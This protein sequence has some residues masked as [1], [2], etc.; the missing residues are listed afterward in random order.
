MK[1][2]LQYNWWKYL[3]I[4]LLP[5]FL[6][7]SVF[8]ALAQPKKNE[9]L[10]I[11]Y[12]G[13]N[14]DTAALQQALRDALPEMTEQNIRE[15][16][17]TQSVPNGISYFDFLTAQCISND[18]I[19]ISQSYC[20]ENTGQGAFARLP[21]ALIDTFPDTAIYTETVEDMTLS[22]GL[23][24]FDGISENRFSAFCSGEEPCYLF[25]CPNSVNFGTKNGRGEADDDAAIKAIEYLLEVTP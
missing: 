13:E 19:L 6:W 10:H 7:C 22:Y 15:V 18:I 12:V 21:Q 25:P 1:R 3:A 8:D 20:Q 14:L 16:T 17:V 23:V 24:L 5:I 2:Y 11:L 9:T 4:I